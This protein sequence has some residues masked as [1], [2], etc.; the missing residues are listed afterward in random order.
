MNSRHV[1]HTKKLSLICILALLL[2][3]FS[4]TLIFAS[5][6]SSMPADHLTD[7]SASA[8]ITSLSG[9]GFHSLALAQDGTVWAAG[10]NASGQLGDGTTTNKL[11]FVQVP[12]IRATS[13]AGGWK[14]T[15]ALKSDGTVWTWGNNDIGQLGDGTFTSRA[16]PVQVSGLSGITAIASRLNHTIALKD[17]GT[18]FTWGQNA[19]GQLGDG[20]TTY[21][22]TP[23]QVSGI[24]GVIAVSAGGTFTLALKN[25]GTVWTWGHQIHG[26]GSTTSQLSPIQVSGLSGITAIASGENHA[27]ALRSDGTVWT[28]GGNG[29]GYL[30]D[31]TTTNRPTPVQV[32]EGV[33]AI[34]GGGIHTIVLKGDGSVWT[35]GNNQLGQLGDGTTADRWTQVK[36][37]G[38]SGVSAIA[39]GWLHTLALTNDGMVWSWGDN[40]EGQL[41]DES[42]TNRS[43]P[44]T[45]HWF[46]SPEPLEGFLYGVILDTTTNEPAPGLTLTFRKGINVTDGPIAATVTSAFG[47][48][49]VTLPYG[50]YTAV[51]TGD[52]YEPATMVATVNSLTNSQSGTITRKPETLSGFLYGVIIDTKTNEPAPGLTLTFRKGINVTDGPIA[53][54]VTSAYG[55][56]GVTLPYG[57]YTAVITGD[58]YEPATMVATVNSLTNSQSGTITPVDSSKASIDAYVSLYLGDSG[59]SL[60]SLLLSKVDRDAIDSAFENLAITIKSS[61]LDSGVTYKG[62]AYWVPDGN[63]HIAAIDANNR[64]TGKLRIQG[65]TPMSNTIVEIGG[66]G[67]IAVQTTDVNLAAGQGN[68][69]KTTADTPFVLVP[70]DVGLIDPSS[71]VLSIGAN[72]I[73]DN[74]DISAWLKIFID[75]QSSTASSYDQKLMDFTRNGIVNHEDFSLGIAARK[76][77][78]PDFVR[79]AYA[80]RADGEVP[81]V[82]LVT[83]KSAYRPGDPVEVRFVM[84]GL[85]AGTQVNSAIFRLTYDSSAFDLATGRVQ[86]DIVDGTIPSAAKT[87]ASV[88]GTLTYLV[89]N[90]DSDYTI[91]NGSTIFSVKMRVKAGASSGTKTF[92][93]RGDNGDL[94][95]EMLDLSDHVYPLSSV[96]KSVTVTVSAPSGYVSGGSAGGAPPSPPA[97]LPG[98]WLTG[99][100]T[101]LSWNPAVLTEQNNG[102]AWFRLNKSSVLSLIQNSSSDAPICTFG[103]DVPGTATFEIPSSVAAAALEKGLCSD[104]LLVLTQAGSYSLPLSTL[105]AIGGL[106]DGVVVRI[107]IAP[108]EQS[109]GARINAAAM[110]NQVT[111]L[112]VPAIAYSLTITKGGETKA[113][114]DFGDVFVQRSM[115]LGKVSGPD[116]DSPSRS[117][118]LFDEKSRSFLFTP[119]RFVTDDKGGLHAIIQR[120]SN[121]TYVAGYKQI[122]FQDIATHWAK[123]A[124]GKLASKGLATGRSEERFEP[125]EAITRAE[126]AALL[127]HA[128]GLQNKKES[129]AFHDVGE[130]D[131]YRH[132][133]LIAQRLGLVT[134][135]NG[136]FFPNETITREELAVMIAR[137]LKYVQPEKQTA[138]ADMASFKDYEQISAWALDA[139]RIAVANGILIGDS[140]HALHPAGTSTRAQAVIMMERLLRKLTMID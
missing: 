66:F 3:A 54:T 8:P 7:S 136:S 139:V 67:Y 26:D 98:V 114:E 24:N 43:T 40:R 46:T 29:Y 109:E 104:S 27:I 41:G 35:W 79:S 32:A 23:V 107:T 73:L 123:S 14:H 47:D 99:S 82:Q 130:N 127:V 2:H 132:E 92:T 84:S 137:A 75:I 74:A 70:G 103:A 37:T 100:R 39:G 128:L 119:A 86:D 44:D 19:N 102:Q 138:K 13:I 22:T 17:D 97:L 81:T 120:S 6:E 30:G 94:S 31:G 80:E 117:I 108:A 129:E 9:G 89:A 52:D 113:I 56:Y 60:N 106:E 45:V 111:R 53:A 62:K 5:S 12:E 85:P 69:L 51:I 78:S 38:I 131:P 4:P 87:N 118:F 55:D 95:A 83:D 116:S 61:Q 126:F 65:I 115:N 28:W 121:S 110:N 133:M 20:T 101:Y 11:I 10:N 88:P 93:F 125:N 15:V 25:D 72:G 71:G 91:T 1:I 58:D 77:F 63:G 135:Y 140:K 36:V 122:R 90:S 64:V 18:V 59:S 68:A 42:L 50:D 124:I 48:Y 134:G 96:S 21:R 34:A 16:K 57:D 76:A 33:V 105:K 49:G 112:P